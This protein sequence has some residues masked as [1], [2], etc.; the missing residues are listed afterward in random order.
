MHHMDANKAYEEKAW[1][2]LY[3]NAASCIE[4]VLEATPHKTADVQLPT[5]YHESYPSYMKQTCGTLLEK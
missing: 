2:Q 3:K 1:G 4:Q 5:T